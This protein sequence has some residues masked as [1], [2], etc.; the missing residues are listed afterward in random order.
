MQNHSTPKSTTSSNCDSTNLPASSGNTSTF[1]VRAILIDSF[2]G[3]NFVKEMDNGM[4]SVQSRKKVVRILVSWLIQEFTSKPPT[5]VKVA[6]A[7]AVVSQFPKLKDLEGVGHVSKICIYAFYK[8]KRC[9][10]T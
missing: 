1:D 4:L 8:I 5:D 2:N 3:E 7:K 6:L 9:R 10:S